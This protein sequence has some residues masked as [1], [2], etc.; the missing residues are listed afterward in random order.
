MREAKRLFSKNKSKS[1]HNQPSSVFKS[2]LMRDL[3]DES[4]KNGVGPGQYDIS[5]P[6][7]KPKFEAIRKNHNT[8]IIKVNE[9]NS[10]AFKSIEPRFRE[11]KMFSRHDNEESTVINEDERSRSQT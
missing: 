9:K 7:V 1:L 4:Y 11:P 3:P 2:K 6:I 10:P 5:L 8:I